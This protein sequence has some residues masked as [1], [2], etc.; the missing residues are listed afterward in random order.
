MTGIALRRRPVGVGLDPAHSVGRPAFSV[1]RSDRG[2]AL[3]RDIGWR[4]AVLAAAGLV[5]R[6]RPGELREGW[7]RGGSPACFA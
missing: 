2:G 3:G 4:A 6:G 5:L 7:T 1:A